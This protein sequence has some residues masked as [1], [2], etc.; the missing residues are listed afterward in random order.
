[1]TSLPCRRIGF[2]A[3]VF[4]LTLDMAGTP[5]RAADVANGRKIASAKCSMCHGV[6]GKATLPEAPNLAG[7]V[8]PYLLEQMK[9]FRDGKR[10]NDV[11]SLVVPTL[12]EN[13]VADVVAYYAT[14]EIKIEK[15]PGQ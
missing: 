7:Q 10:K 12:S 2:T 4:L 9:A 14:I 3:A 11:M 1:M 8:E 5:G 6:D 13:D 15:V